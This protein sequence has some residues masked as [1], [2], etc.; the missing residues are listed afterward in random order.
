MSGRSDCWWVTHYT[1]VISRGM[2]RVR[3]ADQQDTIRKQ[4]AV[5]EEQFE[6][7]ICAAIVDDPA[8]WLQPFQPV[9]RFLERIRRP[10]S[11][12]SA[13]AQG[14]CSNS[15]MAAI[16]RVSSSNS[17]IFRT[18]S[19]RHRS[20]GGAPARNPY[21]SCRISA[22][23]KPQAFPRSR[24]ASRSRIDGSYC[25]RPPMRL[26]FGSRPACS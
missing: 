10:H 3:I 5:R 20:E 16:L 26:G 1:E 21:K 2:D 6:Q 13:H 8:A 9:A 19:V 23:L 7:L 14:R 22:K 24:T 12:R 25:L 15:F 11:P 18:A 4:Y 17:A